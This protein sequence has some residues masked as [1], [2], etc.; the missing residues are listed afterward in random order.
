MV[1]AYGLVKS[2]TESSHSFELYISSFSLLLLI[3]SL[4][5]SKNTLILFYIKLS[6][7]CYETWSVLQES[8]ILHDYASYSIAL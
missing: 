6:L 4:P 7:P 8:G 5:T 3:L 1:N 2:F